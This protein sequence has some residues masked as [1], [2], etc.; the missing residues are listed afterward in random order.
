VLDPVSKNYGAYV[1]GTGGVGT[2]NTTNILPSGQGFFVV[3]TAATAKL[4]F[5]ESA[6]ISTQVTGTSLLMGLPKNVMNYQ[7]MNLMLAKDSVN[8]DDIIIHLKA[9]AGTAY[10]PET[11]AIYHPGFGQV[12]LSSITSDNVALAINS[13]PFPKTRSKIALSVNAMTDGTY[14]LSMKNIVGIPKLYSIWLIDN[15]TKDS[16]DM[17]NRDVYSFTIT[18]SDS[19]SFGAHRFM[20][21]ISQN[22]AYAYHLTNFLA[23]RIPSQ[24][25]RE[26]QLNWYT[27]NESNYTTFTVERS[28]DGGNTFEVVGG[29]QGNGSGYYGLL[30]PNPQTG[31]NVY[32][33]RQQDIDNNISYSAPVSLEY[34]ILSNNLSNSNVHVYPNPA[35]SN[36]TLAIDNGSIAKSPNYKI[37]ISN[38][39]GLMVRDIN[40]SLSNWQGSINDL[41]TGTYLVQ[42]INSSN[43]SLVG[44]T[45]FVKL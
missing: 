38:G 35:K 32:R 5:N 20:L 44:E 26:V 22:P 6:K 13:Q 34:T 17:R 14:Q 30:D 9:D 21:S 24:P 4:I 33:L 27:K 42:V 43:G 2:H 12:N 10:N 36:I 25:T 28:K 23:S 39:S 1:A 37:R 29:K 45:K 19:S 18:K 15:Y 3:A 7:Y 11:E 41:S 16:V 31:L 40:T 8:T